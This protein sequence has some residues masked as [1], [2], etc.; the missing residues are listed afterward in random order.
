MRILQ[1]AL[2]VL[3]AGILF[4]TLTPVTA[5]A[6]S[7]SEPSAQDKAMHY[8]LYWENLKNENYADARNDLRWILDNAPGFPK[9]DDRNYERAIRLYTG[10]AKQAESEDQ[11]KAFIDTAATLLRTAP[12]KMAAAE[13]SYDEYEWE[14]QKGRFLQV[15]ESL[16]SRDLEGLESAAVHYE[17]AFE[18]A[19][20]RIDPYYINQV[21]Q[22]Y[23]DANKQSEALA[24]MEQVESKR[25]DDED[26]QKILSSA[27]TDIFGKNPQARIDFL[28][29]KLEQN[30]DDAKVQQDLF[31]ALVEE[32]YI[33][34]ASQF[35]DKLLQQ[36]SLPAG[37]YLEIANMQLKDGRPADAFSTYEKA[38]ESGAELAAED[39]FN[40]GTA[41]RRAGNLS[42]ARSY[43]RKAIDQKSD[44]GRAYIAIGDLYVRA[45]SDCGGSKMSRKDKAVYWLALDMYQRAKQVDE[46]T[47]STANNNIQT[48]MR[49]MPS[50]EDIFYV[51][52]WEVGGSVRIDYG[53]Y[54]WI[55]E[56]TTVRD[57]S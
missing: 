33:Q 55:N 46:S 41:Q 52:E 49:Y 34:E 17:N 39:Y 48:Y 1:S 31:A 25:G 29:S 14:I 44:F 24:F 20:D 5:V 32:D 43:Y 53:C 50:Q 13:L 2:G 56:T 36:E 11:Q 51:D 9:N 26:V 45:V 57:P 23:A 22:N 21:I 27:R 54:S 8:S 42:Q 15:N 12:E 28:R 40:M 38:I 10:L 19:P 37:T 35:A 3:C 30:P 4:A 7:Q 47:A 6:Q 18:L 16:L